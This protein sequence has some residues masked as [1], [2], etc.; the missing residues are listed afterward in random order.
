MAELQAQ[1][2]WLAGV[3]SI[4]PPHIKTFWDAFRSS[5]AQLAIAA[6]EGDAR[7]FRELR[8]AAGLVADR[9]LAE[10]GGGLTVTL[11]IGADAAAGLVQLAAGA[12]ARKAGGGGG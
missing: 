7:A 3:K 1:R 11:H 2:G 4:S 6:H 5:T 9:R 8:A 12:L 10:A